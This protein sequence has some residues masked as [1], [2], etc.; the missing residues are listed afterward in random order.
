VPDDLDY[1]WLDEFVV[2][3]PH[4][5][6]DDLATARSL[7][8]DQMRAVEEAHPRD[9]KTRDRMQGVVEALERAIGTH[10]R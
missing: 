5:S 2:N 8:A 10:G 6:E 1:V 7:L 3:A 9:Q 4:W